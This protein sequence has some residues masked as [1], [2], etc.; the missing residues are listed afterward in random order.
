MLG[1]S[2]GTL[3]LYKLLLKVQKHL[4][5]L[6]HSPPEIFTISQPPSSV[7]K[8]HHLYGKL[9]YGERTRLVLR[10]CVVQFHDRLAPDSR[11]TTILYNH[12]GGAR[13]LVARAHAPVCPNLAT[14]LGEHYS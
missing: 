2:M 6:G 3:R 10:Y 5:G 13:P 8:P 11:S 4:G 12:R 1:Q 9:A 14:P 7:L